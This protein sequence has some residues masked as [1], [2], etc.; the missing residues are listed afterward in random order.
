M[1]SN[2]KGVISGVNGVKTETLVSTLSTSCRNPRLSIRSNQLGWAR[3]SPLDPLNS[4]EK[5]PRTES[6]FCF[7]NRLK[8]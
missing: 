7:S 5:I 1:T 4:Q 8:R 3:W 6:L 2:V